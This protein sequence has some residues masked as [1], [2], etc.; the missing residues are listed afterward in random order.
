MIDTTT[1]ETVSWP[2][3]LDKLFAHMG[4]GQR[5]S[6]GNRSRRDEPGEGDRY[7]HEIETYVKFWC[8]NP[9]TVM[10]DKHRLAKIRVDNLHWD[11]T[12]EEL[13][14]CLFSVYR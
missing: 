5:Y 7:A 2:I 1:I 8:G 4:T 14:V 9:V 6:R 13:T 3:Y 12:E 11:L 10:T